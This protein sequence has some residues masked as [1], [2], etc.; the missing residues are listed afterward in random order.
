M[1]GHPPTTSAREWPGGKELTTRVVQSSSGEGE[2]ESENPQVTTTLRAREVSHGRADEGP[3]GASRNQ[4]PF[5][6]RSSEAPSHADP[7]TSGS[8]GSAHQWKDLRLERPIID[9]PW[10]NGLGDTSNPAGNRLQHRTISRRD[11]EHEGAKAGSRESNSRPNQSRFPLR[12]GTSPI[13]TAQGPSPC[14]SGNNTHRETEQEG[15]QPGRVFWGFE[16]QVP[17]A[18]PGMRRQPGNVQR[19]YLLTTNDVSR[20]EQYGP[21]GSRFKRSS[22]NTHS[23]Y[24]VGGDHQLGT[25]AHE[26]PQEAAHRRKLKTHRAGPRDLINGRPA[27]R[28][29][30]RLTETADSSSR[31]LDHGC[32]HD[33]HRCQ[34]GL[35]IWIKSGDQYVFDGSPIEGWACGYLFVI[36]RVSE[37]A[38]EWGPDPGIFFLEHV[39]RQWPV[40]Y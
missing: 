34:E 17:T 18:P 7:P 1:S 32:T 38:A 29:A 11:Q 33:E 36:H 4:Q 13:Q 14:N 39:R 21:T 10:S 19:S 9:K 15:L 35:F 37:Q 2:P 3:H 28:E 8:P 16:F 40:H 23:S 24:S 31:E 25:P 22:I 30:R 26:E 5:R 20:P 12:G 6:P 27:G